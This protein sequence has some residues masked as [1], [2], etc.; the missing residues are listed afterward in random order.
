LASGKEQETFGWR[1]IQQSSGIRPAAKV[2]AAA[3][4]PLPA[5]GARVITVPLQSSCNKKKKELSWGQTLPE[6]ITDQ[7]IKLD[8][9]LR[10]TYTPA[11]PQILV[12][13]V[14]EPAA[15]PFWR[16]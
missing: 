13:K 12:G 3:K 7:V 8:S 5:D 9:W 10:G 1:S 2:A 11:T 15:P 16:I 14:I 6:L 4:Y